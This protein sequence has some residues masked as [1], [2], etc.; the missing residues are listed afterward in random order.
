MQKGPSENLS[1]LLLEDSSQRSSLNAAFFSPFTFNN[2]INAF[3]LQKQSKKLTPRM[4]STL[5]HWGVPRFTNAKF[6][7]KEVNLRSENE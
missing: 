1:E 3:S 7:N 2:L 5:S 6:T 4:Q